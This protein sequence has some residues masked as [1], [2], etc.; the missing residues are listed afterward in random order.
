M[1]QSGCS[2]ARHIIHR[3]RKG[4]WILLVGGRGGNIGE[5]RERRAM[6]GRGGISCRAWRRGV[7]KK[8][9]V[10]G[11]DDGRKVGDSFSEQQIRVDP[12]LYQPYW[13]IHDLRDQYIEHILPNHASPDPYSLHATTPVFLMFPAPALSPQAISSAVRLF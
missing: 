1:R 5:D 13:E 7:W 12:F 9:E 10:E 6:Q 11:G 2:L 3:L 4:L 8:G